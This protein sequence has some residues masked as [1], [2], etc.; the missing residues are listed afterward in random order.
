MLGWLYRRRLAR[1]AAA[2]EPSEAELDAI[3]R[4]SPC[5]AR[6]TPQRRE[7]LRRRTGEILAAKE[8]HGA[9][10]LAPDRGDCLPVAVHAGL[11][12][13]D[14]GLEPF[15][16]FRTFI[17]YRDEFEVEIEETD[18]DGLVHRG[19][20]LR[21]GEA[22]HRGPVVL[23]LADVAA[24][25]QGEGYHVV[26]HEIAHQLDQANGDADGYPPL[27]AGVSG[28]DWSETFSAA[29]ERLQAQLDAGAE[30][31]IDEYAAESPAEFFAV[32]S[33]YFFDAPEIL[34]KAEP[35]VYR[36]LASLYG[37]DPD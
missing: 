29:F 24:S 36:L 20:D 9:G 28:R 34:R 3:V 6:L 10:G 2:L 15:R 5:L 27:P 7:R 1:E 16:H 32:A 23:S 37:R 13:L 11:P 30:P 17:L 19:R 18:D 12:M 25:G 26:V 21:A 4:A 8:F 35:G 31:V 33:E 14:L 22:W